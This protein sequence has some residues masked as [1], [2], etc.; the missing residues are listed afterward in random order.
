MGRSIRRTKWERCAKTM[1]TRLLLAVLTASFLAATARATDIFWNQLPTSSWADEEYWVEAGSAE[2]GAFVTVTI[3]K[4]GSYLA[5]G[6]GYR[7]EDEEDPIFAYT[8]TSD[9]GGPADFSA[10]ASSSNG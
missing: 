2:T 8:L 7:W 10:S 6:Q 3:Y 1:K 9:S 4:N 5:S